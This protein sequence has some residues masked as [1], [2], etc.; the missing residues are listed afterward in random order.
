MN[1]A[2]YFELAKAAK[3][4]YEAAVEMADKALKNFPRN[5]IGLTP[6]EVK[7]TPEFQ[8]A[9]KDYSNAFNDLRN[10]NTNFVKE[11]KNEIRNERKIGA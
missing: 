1:R 11:F 4:K 7:S 2:E 6:D 9:K 10:F 8:C 5:S 3:K